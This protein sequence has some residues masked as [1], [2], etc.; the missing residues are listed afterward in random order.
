MT[1]AFDI[2]FKKFA[3]KFSKGYP[4]MKDKHDRILLESLLNELGVKIKLFEEVNFGVLKN[5]SKPSLSDDILKKIQSGETFN[6]DVENVLFAS[7]G[8][9]KTYGGK[10]KYT[11]SDLRT[12]I[13]EFDEPII[14]TYA[15]TVNKLRTPFGVRICEF[16]KASTEKGADFQKLVAINKL[17]S[18]FPNKIKPTERTAAGLGYEKMQVDNLNKNLQSITKQLGNDDVKLFIEGKD[19]G[20]KIASSEKVA[21]SGKADLVLKNSGGNEVF[22][23]SYKEGKYYTGEEKELSKDVPFQQYGSLVTMYSKSYDKE[24]QEFGNYL[25]KEITDFL[26]AAEANIDSKYIFNDVDVKT[27]KDSPDLP[28]DVK[29]YLNSLPW[30]NLEK[31]AGNDKIDVIF[32][33]PATFFKRNFI[34]TGDKQAEILAGKSV[35]GLDYDGK[36]ENFGRENCNV[37]F[38]NDGLL[39]IEPHSTEGVIDGINISPTETGHILY[40]PELPIKPDD[41]DFAYTPSL[42]IRHTKELSFGYESKG[43]KKM[44][45][46]GRILIMPS[47]KIPSNVPS[48]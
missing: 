32:F 14:L 15:G 10:S 33:P 7:G 28:E 31:F 23:I 46:G 19:T 8:K 35:W 37:L 36:P 17:L 34:K 5:L 40:N 24:M 44:I 29:G 16:G 45:M 43:K 4:D 26:D 18:E 11:L 1:N 9:G 47:G 30:T 6:I 42:Y 13:N 22:W 41:P 3:Y 48:V 20:I 25:Q 12:I 27:L 21:G 39:N 38:Q 2:F